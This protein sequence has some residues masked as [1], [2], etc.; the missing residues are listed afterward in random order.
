LSGDVAQLA[1]TWPAH[2][3]AD[4]FP[5]MS[6]EEIADLAADIRENG[7]REPIRL[8]RDGRIIDGRNRWRACVLA[9]VAPTTRVY[10]DADDGLVRFVLSL[11]LQRRHLTTSQRAMVAARVANLGQGARTD[12]AGNQARSGVSQSDAADQ[13]NVSR[14]VTQKARIVQEKGVPELVAAVDGGDISVTKAADV[15]RRP[16]YEQRAVVRAVKDA[17]TE[18]LL[19][20][21]A[22]QRARRQRV[23]DGRAVLQS[24]SN[25]WYTPPQYIDAARVV[26]GRI[27]LDPASCEEAN[28]IVKAETYYTVEDDGLAHDWAGTI[29]LNPPYG[30]LADDFVARLDE[31]YRDGTITAGIA[32]LNAHCTDTRWFRPMWDHVLCFTDHRIDFAPG[33]PAKDSVFTSSTHGSVFAYLGPDP[34][35]FAREFVG[36]GSVVRRWPDGQPP[37]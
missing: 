13:L 32:L 25:E 8:H 24:I 3:A 19:S 31:T 33:S 10:E 17:D 28:E 12:L 5:M 9:D 22:T 4:L 1:E 15:A 36:F 34:E 23:D 6:D 26:L 16:D 27:D 35:A 18:D 30:R 7:L 37:P 11:N 14:D 21:A 2:P 20:M 29:W